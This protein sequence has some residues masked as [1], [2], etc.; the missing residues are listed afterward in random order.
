[1]I[2]LLRKTTLIL[3]ECLTVLLVMVSVAAGVL[4]WRLQQGPIAVDFVKSVL[5]QRIAAHDDSVS[6]TFDKAFLTWPNWREPLVVEVKNLH[7]TQHGE[8]RL[9]LPEAALSIARLPLLVGQ[10]KPV[11]AIFR[12]PDFRFIR[13]DDNRFLLMSA[14]PGEVGTPVATDQSQTTDMTGI[15]ALFH[16]F[17]AGKPTAS[18]VHNAPAWPAFLAEFEAIRVEDAVI[19]FEN[20]DGAIDWAMPHVNVQLER[21]GKG[22]EAQM[23]ARIAGDA[24]M[25]TTLSAI[26]DR[27][28]GLAVSARTN[29]FP[30]ISPFRNFILDATNGVTEFEK[31]SLDASLN[32]SFTN[33]AHITLASGTLDVPTATV[34]L[35]DIL[36][37]ALTVSAAEIGFDYQSSGTKGSFHIR[38]SHLTVND[39]PVTLESTLQ[40]DGTTITG[41]LRM[42]VSNLPIKT[43]HGLWPQAIKETQAGIWLTQKITD[44]LVDQAEFS[45]TLSGTQADQ[46]LDDT[47]DIDLTLDDVW[48]DTGLPVGSVWEWGVSDVV[49]NYSYSGLTL[50][51]HAPL[52]ILTN[53]NGI[54][55]YKDETLN[56]GI[57]EGKLQDITVRKGNVM[58]DQI[59]TKGVESNVVLTLP[60]SGPLSSLMSYLALEPVGL[61]KELLADP[62]RV[63]GTFDATTII[64]F[65][66]IYDLPRERVTVEVAG[67][68]SNVTW[69]EAAVGLPLN[70]GTL[71]IAV[72]GDTLSIKGKGL[73]DTAPVTFDWRRLVVIPAAPEV[74]L[75]HL[76][77][78]LQSNDALRPKLGFP[79]GDS[80]TGTVP[81]DITYSENARRDGEMKIA[82]D[83]TQAG[84]TITPLGYTKPAGQTGNGQGTLV[85]SGNQLTAIR[86]MA[87][88]AAGGK[89]IDGGVMRLRPGKDGPDLVDLTLGRVQLPNQDFSLHLT[90]PQADLYDI[91]ITATKFDARPFL[92]PAP[93]TQTS[94]PV[95]DDPMRYDIALKAATLQTTDKYDLRDATLSLLTAADDSLAA[96]N[97]SASAAGSSL[98]ARFDAPNLTVSAA[99]AGH[100]LRALGI[101]DNI[102]GGRLMV[103]GTAT[104]GRTTAQLKGETVLD[105]FAV[106][107]APALAR[108][109]NALSLT[110]IGGLLDN[111]GI[112]FKR[113]QTQFVWTDTLQSQAI[114][115]DNGRTSGASL[116]LTFEGALNRATHTLDV[117]GTIIP[118][119]EINKFIGNIP[120]IGDILLG[121]KN[122]SLIAATYT[123]KGGYDD[124]QVSINPLSV[125]T[126]GFIRTLLFEQ[127]KAPPA[128]ATTKDRV[129]K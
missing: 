35:H 14:L 84:L 55:S 30:L 99:N 13:T 36:P 113:L 34:T 129:N 47:D 20:E 106:V 100:A 127:D 122:G 52:T 120:I 12:Q 125:L 49:A 7:L 105:D 124:P 101:Y 33:T 79:S 4:M 26:P 37:S 1:M 83:L 46:Q 8:T 40:R 111:K 63:T 68:A 69:P 53:A 81:L 108:L 78:N 66:A 42:Q 38:P 92:N 85:F 17:A 58:I 109:L 57:T 56:V 82:A 48:A 70:N 117:R 89:V 23:T 21:S 102:M 107:K 86:D 28:G 19:V 27:D 103:T 65:P 112:H 54:G 39:A 123:L 77:A 25:V 73:F 94:P 29:N 60:V 43:L 15:I 118:M 98:N 88:S 110:G 87:L 18:S 41:P 96:L 44:G 5:A 75:S 104:N 9:H 71:D 24:P 76:T 95:Q 67:K 115:F 10:I 3:L 22:L 31:T 62:K 32:V 119:S 59:E 72:N 50:D 45:L 91:D 6:L 11:A 93:T 2:P 97:I 80:V 116:G 16:S 114:T 128:P 61:D 51:Y 126:P 74:E 121:G 64:R 90:R